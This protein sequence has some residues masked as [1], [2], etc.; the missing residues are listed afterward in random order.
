MP[1]PTFHQGFQPV[2]KLDAPLIDDHGQ[3]TIPWYRFFIRL[4]NS[5]GLN[6]INF[7]NTAFL[8]S[9]PTA[10]TPVT[11]YG[12]G[13]TGQPIP[14]GPVPIPGSSA[15]DQIAFE[16]LQEVVLQDPPPDLTAQINL[17]LLELVA[18]C[19]TLVAGTDLTVL[20]LLVPA[21]PPEENLGVGVLAF[22]V[23]N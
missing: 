6:F 10:T 5:L 22:V 16:A 15:A 14:I 4:W 11:V 21:D 20:E 19:D 17:D 1:D 3:I 13:P 18:P 2:P 8:T 23:P 7:Q 12:V 9:T